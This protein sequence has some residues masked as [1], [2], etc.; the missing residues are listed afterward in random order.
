[1]TLCTELNKLW[2][3][4]NFKDPDLKSFAQ[5]QLIAET[6]EGL[7]IMSTLLILLILLAMLFFKQ[8]SLINGYSLNY[9]WV[10]ALSAHINISSRVVSE[11]KTLHALGMTLLVISAT[12]YVFIAHQ[13]GGFSP[14]LLV[15]I[16]LLFMVIPIIPWG[17]R[18]AI[19][20]I[21]SIYLLL[22]LSTLNGGHQFD[23]ETLRTLQFFLLAAGITSIMLVVRTTSVRKKELL[24]HFDLQKAHAEL[25]TLSNIDPLTGAWNRRYIDQAIIDLVTDFQSEHSHL[26]FIIFDL[27]KFK[28]LNDTFGHDFGDRVLTVTANTIKQ[29]ANR[30]GQLIRI[31]GDEFVLLLV[32]GDANAFMQ[33]VRTEIKSLLSKEQDRAVFD[34]SWGIVTLPLAR[35]QDSETVYQQ[36]DSALYKHKKINKNK[37]VGFSEAKDRHVYI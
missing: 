21:V 25:Y 14:L 6:Q 17:L 2:S 11:I 31:G 9:F 19:I 18:E 37:V 23:D 36:A 29:T 10:I 22:T 20:I 27:D 30:K 3:M 35:I 33:T 12:A 16:V 13:L 28:L 4:N 34:F 26:H 7:K 5:Q 15:N 24:A 32:G 8:M 1:M